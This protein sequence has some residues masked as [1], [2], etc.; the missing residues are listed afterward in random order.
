MKKASAILWRGAGTAGVNQPDGAAGTSILDGA[1]GRAC[2]GRSANRPRHILMPREISD[3]GSGGAS[4]FDE[5]R[6]TPYAGTGPFKA[7]RG[8]GPD[9]ADAHALLSRRVARQRRKTA[10]HSLGQWR[11]P[12]HLGRVHHVPG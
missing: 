1:R 6:K 4:R 3:R 7:T 5:W 10:G 8:R 11:L 12:Q 9:A 2:N